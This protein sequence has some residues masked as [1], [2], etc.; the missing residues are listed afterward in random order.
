M[1]KHH[2]SKL[3]GEDQGTPTVT[4]GPGLDLIAFTEQ[5]L[6]Y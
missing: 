3:V 5:P 6:S 1:K 4:L 2:L